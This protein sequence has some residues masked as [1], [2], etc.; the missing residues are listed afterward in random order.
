MGS[1]NGMNRDQIVLFPESVDEYIEANHPVRFIDASVDSLNLTGLGLTQTV[2]KDT[3][4]PRYA[5]ADMLKLYM[6]GYLQKIRSR[7]K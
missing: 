1:I 2:R 4:R 5:L 7:R 6:Y 3:G